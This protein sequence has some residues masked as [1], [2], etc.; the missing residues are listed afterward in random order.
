MIPISMVRSQN[1]MSI[2]AN[3]VSAML[4]YCVKSGPVISYR[5]I[6]CANS[7]ILFSWFVSTDVVYR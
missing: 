3:V 5:L 4:W 1:V 2:V 6:F 7:N